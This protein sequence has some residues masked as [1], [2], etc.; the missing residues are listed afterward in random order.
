MKT[1]SSLRDYIK[2]SREK[3]STWPS[4]KKDVMS[5]VSRD[6]QSGQFVFVRDTGSS[7]KNKQT[8]K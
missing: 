4:W 3:V 7:K 8:N 5:V 1:Q 6:S 2:G